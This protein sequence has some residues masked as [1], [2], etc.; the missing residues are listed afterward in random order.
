MLSDGEIKAA[1][2]PNHRNLSSVFRDNGIDIL[3]TVRYEELGCFSYES[4]LTLE[5]NVESVS[6]VSINA[7]TD[8]MT[9][10]YSSGTTG[11]PKGVMLT[12]QNLLYGVQTAKNELRCTEI[13]VIFTPVPVFHIFGLVPGVL[14]TILTGAKIVFMEK[15]NKVK[16]LE[17]IEK[18]HV[19]IHLGVPTMFI[20]ELN[21]MNQT[22]YDLSSLRTGIIAGSCCPSHVVRKIR[23]QMGCNIKISYGM[24]ETTSA[25]TFTSFDDDDRLCSETVGKAVLGTEIKIV[26][27]N[28]KEVPYGEIGELAC[29]GIGVMKGY[30]NMPEETRKVIDRNGWYY[31]GDLATLNEDGYYSIVG[32]K[33]DMI[34]RGG[35][36]IYPS[37]VEEVLY[38]HPSVLDVAIVGVPNP[39]LGENSRAF[40][41]LKNN[42]YE[43]EESLKNYLT[44]KIIKY[45]IPD[46]I[47]FLDELPMNPNGKILKNKLREM[48][49]KQEDSYYTQFV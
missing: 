34:T 21:E 28:H 9:I 17:L 29:K 36:K 25:V 16:A 13:D 6:P 27:E 12:H 22:A 11:R 38:R 35:Y 45:K 8:V 39:V 48:A 3:V 23:N 40:I 26:D 49:I 19:T 1:F 24:T 5:S 41:K 33:K 32:R 46:D 10:L 4:L 18:E 30:H 20:L 37:E 44:D 7:E 2:F 42:C 15:F 14:L 31:T 47:V 43:S